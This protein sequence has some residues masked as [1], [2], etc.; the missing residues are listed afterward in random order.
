MNSLWLNEKTKEKFPKLEKDLETQVCIIGA[1][2]FG[3]ST[4]YYLTQKGYNVTILERD[5]VVC[6]QQTNQK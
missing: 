4:A 3:I 6:I 1:G 2:I 5:K